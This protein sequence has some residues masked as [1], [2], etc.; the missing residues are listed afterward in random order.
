MGVLSSKALTG[1][2]LALIGLITIKVLTALFGA[3]MGFFSFLL[4]ILPILLIGWLLLKV[5]KHFGKDKKAAYSEG[6]QG[7]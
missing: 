5:F 6:S 4:S 7:L 3:V 2:I 1:G